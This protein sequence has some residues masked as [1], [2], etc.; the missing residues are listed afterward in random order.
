MVEES[1]QNIINQIYETDITFNIESIKSRYTDLQYRL[2]ES[3]Q[4]VTDTPLAEEEVSEKLSIIGNDIFDFAGT[5]GT[6]SLSVNDIS[7]LQ[8]LEKELGTNLNRLKELEDT[9]DQLERIQERKEDR[10]D[11]LASELSEFL[12]NVT[13]DEVVQNE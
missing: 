13:E 5:L 8:E 12:I 6:A 7:S 9:F 3:E 2:D 4:L 11:D 1:I 10:R